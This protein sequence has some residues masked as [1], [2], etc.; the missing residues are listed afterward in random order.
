MSRIYIDGQYHKTVEKE[1]YAKSYI[2][3]SASDW[4]NGA[5]DVC[6]VTK[7][8]AYITTLVWGGGLPHGPTRWNLTR[9]ALDDP[10]IPKAV[11]LAESLLH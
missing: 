5:E 6:I 7:T 1:W 4:S 2:A 9:V 8:A 3:H 11:Q 10:R